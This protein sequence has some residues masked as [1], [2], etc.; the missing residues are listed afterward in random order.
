MIS[1]LIIITIVFIAPVCAILL[2]QEW[3]YDARWYVVYND[4]EKSCKMPK[5]VA[6][7]YADIFGGT[8]YRKPGKK[9]YQRR[10]KATKT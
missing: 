1:F 3:L 2:W 7:D 9:I 10:K 8:V 4:G 5:Y 6:R